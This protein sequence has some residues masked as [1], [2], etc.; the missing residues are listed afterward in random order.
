[1]STQTSILLKVL[2]FL[3]MIC[4]FIAYHNLY[5]IGDATEYVIVA[6]FLVAFGGIFL[7][8]WMDNRKKKKI[9]AEQRELE[10]KRKRESNSE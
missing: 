3:M 10:L 9:K 5:D 4:S 6:F 7:N 8:Q 1:M 2:L